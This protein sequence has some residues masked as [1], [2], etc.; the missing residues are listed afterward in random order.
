MRLF[1]FVGLIFAVVCS[2][3]H[4]KKKQTN[5]SEKKGVELILQDSLMVR[6][7]DMIDSVRYIKLETNE[8]CLLGYIKKLELYE[9]KI[10]IQDA[11]GHVYVFDDTGHF[12]NKIGVRG[13]GPEE[14]LGMINFY[15]DKKISG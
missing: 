1:L 7:P 14:Y 10:F 9:G 5:Y 6:M 12:L 4:S 11:N 2:S 13:R 8:Q 15:L 3:C